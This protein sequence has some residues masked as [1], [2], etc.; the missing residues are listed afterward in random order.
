MPGRHLGSGGRHP[1]YGLLY[2]WHL[3]PGSPPTENSSRQTTMALVNSPRPNIPRPKFLPCVAG[4]LCNT[5]DSFPHFFRST[6]NRRKNLMDIVSSVCHDRCPEIEVGSHLVELV[7]AEITI[8]PRE[9]SRGVRQSPRA[10][11]Q[12]AWLAMVPDYPRISTATAVAV[13]AA[14]LSPRYKI[15]CL[16]GLG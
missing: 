11:D 10:R 2:H 1:V 3:R 15:S 13:A 7:A 5:C 14:Q 16:A 9:G 6:E 4:G 12:S 8:R